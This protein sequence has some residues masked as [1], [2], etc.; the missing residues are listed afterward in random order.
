MG[1]NIRNSFFE[2]SYTRCV[3]ESISRLFTK[4]LELSM[5]LD[6]HSKV[7]F[8]IKVL[9]SKSYRNILKLRCKSLASISYKAFL[10]NKRRSITHFFIFS[11]YTVLSDQ[12]S[13]SLLL[14][15]LGNMFIVIV[16]DL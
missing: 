16:V 8:R 3:G 14:A 11:C 6:E 13:L 9:Y 5:S 7:L 4:K 1:C 15:I 10:K 12:V 2:N